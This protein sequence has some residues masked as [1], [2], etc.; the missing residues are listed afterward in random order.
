MNHR[1]EPTPQAPGDALARE[2]DEPWI[3]H[4]VGENQKLFNRFGIKISD[5]NIATEQLCEVIRGLE[6]AIAEEQA[7]TKLI[8]KALWDAHKALH[9]GEKTVIELRRR[10]EEAERK[11]AE[12]WTD[13]LVNQYARYRKECFEYSRPFGLARDWLAARREERKG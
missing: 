1:V 13:D 2:K 6:T 11:M 9:A 10:L 12:M 7:R 5:H 8:E 4:S 3:R